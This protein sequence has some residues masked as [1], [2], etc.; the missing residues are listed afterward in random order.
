MADEKKPPAKQD[1]GAEE[2][3]LGLPI[4]NFEN[5]PSVDTTDYTKNYSPEDRKK[6]AES[7]AKK[8]EIAA[9]AKQRKD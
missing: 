8:L 2:T 9:R 3:Y 6:I 1:E 5:E 7:F 4:R